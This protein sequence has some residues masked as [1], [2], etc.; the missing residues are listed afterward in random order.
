MKRVVEKLKC[1][2]GASILLALLFLLVCV[3]VAMSVLMAAASNAGKIRSNREEQQKYF[4]LSSALNLVIAEL[5]G[6]EYQ[7]NYMI[8]K[9]TVG[10]P[11]KN[12]LTGEE[13]KDD[14]GNTIMEYHDEYSGEQLPGN[15]TCSLNSPAV[16][17]LSLVDELDKNVFQK[18]QKLPPVDPPDFWN[19][20]FKNRD[21]PASVDDG[22]QLKLVI[23]NYPKDSP[24]L[25]K[26]V[27]IDVTVNGS[28]DIVLLAT[29]EG[30]EYISMEATLGINIVEDFN[31]KLPIGDESVTGPVGKAI[32]KLDRIIKKEVAGP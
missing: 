31:L 27:I 24:G 15:F 32:W 18:H 25:G 20:D 14:E 17:V 10:V 5:E 3:L 12:P 4:T 13:M 16:A 7:G 19:P 2:R 30:E 6:A 9:H 11:K 8:E 26:A 22:H 21:F 1:R 29:L 23:D 28:G